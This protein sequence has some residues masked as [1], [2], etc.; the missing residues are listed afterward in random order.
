MS[1]DMFS[2]TRP[3]PPDPN[4]WIAGWVA[5]RGE[6]EMARVQFL[7]LI[8]AKG[9]VIYEYLIETDSEAAGIAV[10]R[11]W[12]TSA[13]PAGD[14]K[15]AESDWGDPDAIRQAVRKIEFLADGR[16][17]PYEDI[18]RHLGLLR[19]LVGR[20]APHNLEYIPDAATV[21]DVVPIARGATAGVQPPSASAAPPPPAKGPDAATGEN[22]P[23][24]VPAKTLAPEHLAAYR[25]A[26][27]IKVPATP[28]PSTAKPFAARPANDPHPPPPK[29]SAG[30]PFPWS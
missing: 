18:K 28:P 1:D 16:R 9:G 10:R 5:K 27:G 30:G 13:T 21:A 25:Q 4:R 19:S 2:P 26:A 20:F 22:R 15:R 29:P 8:R 11:K 14:R 17:A 7:D 3:E 6:H 24:P 23:S 12:P